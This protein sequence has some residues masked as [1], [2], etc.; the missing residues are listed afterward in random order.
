M[1]LTILHITVAKGTYHLPLG[2]PRKHVSVDELL[3]ASACD[4]FNEKYPPIYILDTFSLQHLSSKNSKSLHVYSKRLFLSLTFVFLRHKP[5]MKLY[6]NM[7][8]VLH[9]DV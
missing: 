4:K 6:S 3:S 7:N 2:Y 1:W 5:K 8:P 9:K